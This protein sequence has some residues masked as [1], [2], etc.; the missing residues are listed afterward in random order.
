[1]VALYQLS[2][3]AWNRSELFPALSSKVLRAICVERGIG[4]DLPS[5][6][7]M[8]PPLASRAAKALRTAGRSVMGSFPVR[9]SSSAVAKVEAG[10]YDGT[11]LPPFALPGLLRDKLP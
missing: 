3:S 10:I 6:V 11:S 1:M 9:R 4:I 8:L 5:C 7:L 2:I